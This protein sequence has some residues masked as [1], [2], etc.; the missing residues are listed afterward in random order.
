MIFLKSDE[1]YD[2]S[3]YTAYHSWGS[4]HSLPKSTPKVQELLL[5]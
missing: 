5:C 4:V 1:C 2:P 3:H